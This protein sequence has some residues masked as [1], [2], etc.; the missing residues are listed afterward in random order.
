MMPALTESFSENVV[1]GSPV[2]PCEHVCYDLHC[3]K[4]IAFGHPHMIG[5]VL[6]ILIKIPQLKR[7]LSA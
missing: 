1:G 3:Y 5:N 6:Y 7:A 4:L 2:L